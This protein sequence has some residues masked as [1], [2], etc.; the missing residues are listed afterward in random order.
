[1]RRTWSDVPMILPI[2]DRQCGNPQGRVTDAPA[3]C[4]Y[5]QHVRRRAP[6]CSAR[7]AGP[8]PA[9]APAL[10]SV[11]VGPPSVMAPGRRWRVAV[12][13][14]PLVRGGSV[15]TYPLQAP[16]GLS[17]GQQGTLPSDGESSCL[18]RLWASRIVAPSGGDDDGG[19]ASAAPRSRTHSASAFA[20]WPL[21]AHVEVRLATMVLVLCS[22]ICR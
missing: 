6:G 13:A 16:R 7:T 10:A 3:G 17:E 14:A 1:L 19:G 4:R 18:L 9:G 15:H 22:I 2:D 8:V 12:D 5:P 20:G 21:P 11:G